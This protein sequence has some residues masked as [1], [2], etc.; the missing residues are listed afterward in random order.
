MLL[1]RAAIRVNLRYGVSGVF[2]GLLI[3]AVTRI[4]WERETTRHVI[5]LGLDGCLGLLGL[6]FAREGLLKIIARHKF[7][8][9]P[10]AI[11]EFVLF[12]LLSREDRETIPGDLAEEFTT[13]IL[14]K[15]GPARAW[16]W[17]WF[18]VIRTVA[19]RSILFRWLLVGGLFKISTWITRKIWG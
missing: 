17:Y 15:F 11:G 3:L 16:F 7:S 2:V 14:P 10:S 5:V 6:V 18:Q 1:D 4:F 8:D 19:Y 13:I 12:V 9:K